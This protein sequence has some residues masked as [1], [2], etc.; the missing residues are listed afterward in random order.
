MTIIEVPDS[1]SRSSKE[2][3]YYCRNGVTPGLPHSLFGLDNP[4]SRSAGTGQDAVG[5]DRLVYVLNLMLPKVLML[6]PDLVLDSVMDKSKR[7]GRNTGTGEDLM[8][9]ERRVVT[10]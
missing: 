2:N 4:V 8:L 5:P 3:G 6:Q 10:F 1:H 7:R 9:A